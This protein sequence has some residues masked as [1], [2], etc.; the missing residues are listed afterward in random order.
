MV[1]TGGT[2]QI[3]PLQLPD[4]MTVEDAAT[5]FK[6]EVKEHKTQFFLKARTARMGSQK[7]SELLPEVQ[8]KCGETQLVETVDTGINETEYEKLLNG[9]VILVGNPTDNNGC[10]EREACSG[11]GPN[12]CGNLGFCP[13]NGKC[14]SF[15][16]V[17]SGSVCVR[18]IINKDDRSCSGSR[19]CSCADIRDK[20][21]LFDCSKLY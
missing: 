8:S 9:G 4:T 15:H 1:K 16:Q 10:D 19:L 20:E 21:T 18:C 11:V 17:S 14:F 2:C 7:R 3:S 6:S 5:A 13:P 12:A